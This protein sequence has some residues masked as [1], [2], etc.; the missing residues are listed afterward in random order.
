LCI[1]ILGQDTKQKGIITLE[2]T[3]G[4]I[5]FYIRKGKAFARKAGGGFNAKA[6]KSSP[7]M[8][9]VRENNSEFGN[10]SSV[11]KEFKLAVRPFMTDYNDGTLHGRMMRLFQ[12]I[13]NFDSVSERGKRNVSNGISSAM[14]K[15]LLADFDFTLHCK[16]LEILKTK[17][18]FEASAVRFDQLSFAGN[19]LPFLHHATHLEIKFGILNFDFSSYE[20]SWCQ[21]AVLLLKKEDFLSANSFLAASPLPENSRQIAV[22]SLRYFQEVGGDFYALKGEGCVGVC[23]LEVC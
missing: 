19:E 11:K 3:I 23:V 18:S 10:C 20:S 16:T 14:G 15:H 2:G 5:N 13:K 17:I 12:E 4:G 22:L 8:V 7:K 21:G 6:I 9:R 1:A